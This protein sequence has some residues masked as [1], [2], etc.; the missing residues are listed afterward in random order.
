MYKALTVRFQRCMVIGA[1]AVQF[2]HYIPLYRNTQH[3][4]TLNCS[5]KTSIASATTQ[6]RLT[7]ALALISCE[8]CRSSRNNPHYAPRHIIL[9]QIMYQYC[10]NNVLIK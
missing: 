3:Y 8:H 10:T 7:Y 9:L 2:L 5:V 4:A 6:L 1:R